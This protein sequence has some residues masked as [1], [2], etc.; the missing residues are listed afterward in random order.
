MGGNPEIRPV[1]K[2]SK[3]YGKY[4]INEVQCNRYVVVRD[5]L[6]ELFRYNNPAR[7]FSHVFSAFEIQRWIIRNLHLEANVSN[8][9][10]FVLCFDAPLL[11]P[12]QKRAEQQRRDEA[13]KQK[14]VKNADEEEKSSDTEQ[15]SYSDKF[16]FEETTGL[17]IDPELRYES[18]TFNLHM[19][20][21]NRNIRGGIICQ[22]LH[23]VLTQPGVV[24]QGSAV[25]LD[26][27][28][29]DFNH[30]KVWAYKGGSFGV[31]EES[32]PY[33]RR[34]YGESDIEVV[35]WAQYFGN[36]HVVI[37]SVDTDMF[38]VLFHYLSRDYHEVDRK[39]FWRYLK[40]AVVDMGGLLKALQDQGWTAETFM[41]FFAI[42]KTDYVPLY[43]L[44]MNSEKVFEA[45]VTSDQKHNEKVQ[46]LVKLARS[47][48]KR[49]CFAFCD[50]MKL[51]KCKD[52][53][54]S[55][56]SSR[57]DAEEKNQNDS[58][59]SADDR[60]YHKAFSW[61]CKYIE[62]DWSTFRPSDNTLSE[63]T[64]PPLPPSSD[65]II[66]FD[67]ASFGARCPDSYIRELVASLKGNNVF[68]TGY[69]PVDSNSK[70]RA[71]NSVAGKKRSIKKTETE[72][73]SK[74]TKTNTKTKARRATSV[75]P[76]PKPKTKTKT[77][78]NQ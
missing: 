63:L 50:L 74:K 4:F 47:D 55:S 16:Y 29:N 72:S 26:Y 59:I 67:G 42:R 25:V 24:P 36:Y 31:F 65:Q 1:L 53:H 6:T 48:D 44:G 5:F 3:H 19:L 28:N 27:H 68:S 38:P 56:L 54:C 2:S 77:K 57:R 7:G 35:K 22:L 34:Y 17:F 66:M 39:V 76:K 46:K 61:H 8:P 60:E 52:H 9:Y 10:A 70:A 20:L 32:S 11:V 43:P 37:D 30:K 62:A 69:V 23:Q 33:S 14:K 21:S 75:K 13:K 40:D 73:S 64:M 41:A 45:F 49:A 51:I 18:D 58:A 12:P 71:S 15:G 78:T